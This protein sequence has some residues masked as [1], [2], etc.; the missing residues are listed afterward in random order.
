MK[1]A[2][3]GVRPTPSTSSFPSVVLEV[4]DSESLTQLIIDAKLWIEHV[5]EVRQ[6]FPWSPPTHWNFLRYNSSYFFR[7]TTLLLT[8]MSRGSP[9]NCGEGFLPFVLRA[10][11][12]LGKGKPAWYGRLTGLM[13]QH[14]CTYYF[15]TSSEDRCRRLMVIMIVCIWTLQVGDRIL[16]I[17]GNYH[18]F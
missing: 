1:Q 2:D 18:Y 5:P 6:F 11:L 17:I 3:A 10:R 13:P 15:L 4:G 9:S 8:Q 14:H 16:L 12:E 7:S